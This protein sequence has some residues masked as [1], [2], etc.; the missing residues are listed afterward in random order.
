MPPL[1]KQGWFNRC[2][3]NPIAL[4]P[5]VALKYDRDYLSILEPEKL[6]MLNKV[7]IA[8][9]QQEKCK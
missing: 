8:L 3:W 9:E 6:V 4:K 1:I 7:P 5:A 2:K